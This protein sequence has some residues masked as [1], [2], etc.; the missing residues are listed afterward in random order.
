MKFDY[1]VLQSG[2]RN[3]H[4]LVSDCGKYGISRYTYSTRKGNV[5][6]YWVAYFRPTGQRLTE[7]KYPT[8]SQA[9]ASAKLHKDNHA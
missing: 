1:E 9:K 8:L 6:T 4:R 5:P 2:K 3:E 7:E